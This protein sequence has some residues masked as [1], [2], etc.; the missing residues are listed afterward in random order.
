MTVTVQHVDDDGQPNGRTEEL[1][2]RYLVGADGDKGFVRKAL[3][4]DFPTVKLTGRALRQIDAKLEWQRSTDADQ[5]WFFIYH[6]GF[7]GV[8]PVWEGYHRM[9]FLEDEDAMP[10]RKPTCEELQTRGREITGDETLTFTDPIWLSHS[11]F[12]HGVADHYFK[13]RVYL[14]GDAG[15]FTLPIGGQ[16]MNAGMHDAVGIAWR[17]AMT[18]A[19]QASPVVLQSYDGERRGE[20]ADLDES[21]TKGF[22]RLV[23]R[24]R[25]EDAL[26]DAAGKLVPNL[27]SKL[28]GSDDL[29]QLSVA[30]RGSLLS[31]DHLKLRQAL[32]K[33]VPHAGDRAPDADLIDSD[34]RTVS[35]FP[36][37]YNAEGQSWGWKPAG[38]RRPRRSGGGEPARRL[39][40]RGAL[41]LRQADA[42]RFR[43]RRDGDRGRREGQPVR[44]RRRRPCRLRPERHVGTGADP[45]RR[46]HRLP[47]PGRPLRSFSPATA[48][49]CSRNRR[50]TVRDTRETAVDDIDLDV[51]IVGAGPSGMLLGAALHR[52]GTRCRIVDKDAGPTD[53]TRAP[54]L[55]QR[56]QE[57]LAALGIRDHWLPEAEEV[58]EES[59][60]LYGKFAGGLSLSA[61]NSPYPQALYAGQDVTERLLDAHMS[62]IG[63]PVEYGREV[64]SY[65]GD[66]RSATVTISSDAGEE[67]TVTARWVVSAEG[68]HSVVRRALGLDFAGEK[69]V[70]YRIHIA[71]VH[72]RWTIATPIGQTFFFVEKGGYMG[73]QRMPGHPDRFYFYI[74]TADEDPSVESD[75]LSIEEAERL[76][77]RFSGDE[78]ATLSEPRWLNAARYRHGLART[79]HE[80]RAFL[81]GDAARSAPPLYG[82]GMNYAMQDA[83]NLAWKLAHVVNGLAPETLLR[84]FDAERRKVGADLDARID[85]TFRF[86]TQPKPLQATAIK[87]VAPA[88]LR[89]GLVDRSFNQAF[90]EIAVGYG[91]VGLSQEASSLGG[92]N[93]GDRAPAL[94]V[95]RL[96][97]CTHANLLDLFDGLR[98]TLLAIAP[99]GD[100]PATAQSLIDQALAKQ[101]AFPHA[102]RAVLLSHGPR[103]PDTLRME[104]V[105]DAE[106]RYPR[107]HGLPATGLLL[108]RPD[109]YIGWA[110]SGGRALD[111]YCD[112]WLRR[113]PG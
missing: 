90:T 103:R 52:H 46:S 80:D 8:L 51:L 97:D 37:L 88:L 28:F 99:A 27:G 83:W 70:G 32:R 44:S 109:G 24:N 104:T 73:G 86:I 89:S 33:G 110:G 106:G 66:A 107:D 50:R 77:R 91:G 98:W 38:V 18:I 11:K 85:G 111:A 71:D 67:E 15:H 76:V 5:I 22:R 34:G 36:L 35:L 1:R 20:H 43:A 25:V 75:E 23:Y 12:Q 100:D 82:Q 102:L 59:L 2:C 68:S 95:K 26:L 39:R 55:W 42:D 74:L 6:N 65:Q 101:M 60:H 72:A 78:A 113:M 30:Y 108:V 3:G 96:P 61:P 84:T 58:R 9:F 4:L 62:A 53:L 63:M 69:Y 31:E 79:Y 40:H 17:L 64:L 112:R 54:V 92:L 10:D 21:Q 56:T 7:A 93:G 13:G 41:E 105:V 14:V 94:W 57:I 16:G 45:S 81:I 49:R 87:A 29:Q 48:R 19:G 47:R